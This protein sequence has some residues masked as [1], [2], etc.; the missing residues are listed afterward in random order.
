MKK[1]VSAPGKLIALD[2]LPVFS[3]IGGSVANSVRRNDF[4]RGSFLDFLVATV[5]CVRYLATTTTEKYRMSPET[6][7]CS[8]ILSTADEEKRG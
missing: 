8:D 4:G 3:L 7:D 6:A 2:R 5:A 1:R